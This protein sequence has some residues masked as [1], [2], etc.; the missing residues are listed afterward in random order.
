M[1]GDTQRSPVRSPRRLWRSRPTDPLIVSPGR[2]S[3]IEL[4]TSIAAR[5]SID[6]TWQPMAL[7]AAYRR[8]LDDRGIRWRFGYGIG[9]FVAD[10]RSIAVTRHADPMDLAL[11]RR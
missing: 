6:P 5:G 9:H 8:G 3:G 1:R 10:G 11:A 2:D 7:L 4:L